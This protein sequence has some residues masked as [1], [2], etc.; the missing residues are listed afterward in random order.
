MHPNVEHQVHFKRALIA[1]STLPVN[2]WFIDSGTT[3][4]LCS[5]V[6]LF[7]EIH[8][9]PTPVKIFLGDNRYVLATGNGKVLQPL[10]LSFVYYGLIL[11][12]I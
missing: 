2:A 11:A 9:L 4:H 10:H 8:S 3:D 1:G 6:H 7:E 12:P 5:Q